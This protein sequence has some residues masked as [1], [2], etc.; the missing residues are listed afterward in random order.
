[1]Q[2]SEDLKDSIIELNQQKK[3]VSIDA[4]EIHIE[5]VEIIFELMTN[6][7]SVTELK[8]VKL[9]DL[10]KKYIESKVVTQSSD[11]T[12]DDDDD[13]DIDQYIRTSAE[14]ESLNS[15]ENF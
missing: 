3:Y 10:V 15:V 5:H 4:H 2:K 8:E 13:D 6:G 14:I 9:S 1:M 11:L 12:S 7:A